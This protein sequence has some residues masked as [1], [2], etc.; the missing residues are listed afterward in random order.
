MHGTISISR[1][2]LIQ[3]F[4][5]DGVIPVF[6]HN[7]LQTIL[8]VLKLVHR[9]GA[10]TFEFVHQR[11]S[12]FLNFFALVAEAARE[13]PGMQ[14][15]VGTVLDHK[16]AKQYIRLGAKFIVSPFLHP[17]MGEICHDHEILWVPGCN[18]NHDVAQAKE[19]GAQVVT[20]LSGTFSGPGF[21][22]NMRNEMPDVALI[23]SCGIR[24]SENSWKSWFDAGSLCIRLGE[25]LFAK[26]VIAVRDWPKLETTL[27][28]TFHEIQQ[29][30][31][32][33]RQ[34]AHSIL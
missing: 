30:K 29:I 32:Q 33:L 6:Q 18:S 3:T 14:V 2:E 28:S 27:F 16:M 5:S 25:A 11:D 4:R 13:L 26:E 12:R 20:V 21:V 10:R 19:L 15:G 34:K 7:D 24:I 22:R 9:C 8:R 17:A 1:N 31:A 23:P